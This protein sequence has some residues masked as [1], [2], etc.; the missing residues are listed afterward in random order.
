MDTVGRPVSNELHVTETF[1]RV[2]HDRLEMTVVIDDPKMYTKPWV[3]MNK[4]PMKLADPHTDVME[5]YCSP[6][7][8]ETYDREVANPVSNGLSNK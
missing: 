4:W 3:A 7:E 5:M 8:Q 2:N 6:L 1:H